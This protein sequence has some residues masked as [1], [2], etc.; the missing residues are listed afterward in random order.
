MAFERP[1]RALIDQ[2][3]TKIQE[4]VVTATDVD[5][6]VTVTT[7]SGDSI[8]MELQSGGDSGGE[9]IGR[10]QGGQWASLTPNPRVAGQF[11]ARGVEYAEVSYTEPPR[12]AARFELGDIVRLPGKGF[13]PKGI[14]HRQTGPVVVVD[15]VV[16]G[17]SMKSWYYH[18][19][20]RQGVNGFQVSDSKELDEAV[21]L[22]RWPLRAGDF[23]VVHPKHE[24]VE[25]PPMKLLRRVQEGDEFYY[26]GLEAW[27]LGAEYGP[28][29]TYL[30]DEDAVLV[31][32][33][34][35]KSEKWTLV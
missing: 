5:G 12:P 14:P 26:E 2:P 32:V 28:T 20:D 10:R 23:V 9:W 29:K 24:L 11:V 19:V 21:K 35:E 27:H 6:G 8:N 7:L 31:D 1:Q 15:A 3:A 34:V 4:V 17:E 13:A 33:E 22:D 18:F 30:R 16:W 25:N